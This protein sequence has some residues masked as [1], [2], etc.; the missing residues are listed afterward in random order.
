MGGAKFGL[1]GL[2]ESLFLIMKLHL[3]RRIL[4]LCR[5][6]NRQKAAAVATLTLA[7]WAVQQIALNILFLKRTVV[8]LIINNNEI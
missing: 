8:H 4:Q 3:H 1:Q 6:Q 2:Q 7:S 5:R